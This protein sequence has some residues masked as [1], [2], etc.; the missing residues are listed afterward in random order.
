MVV[1][2]FG[3]MAAGDL[4]VRAE[5]AK[6]GSAGKGFAVVAEEVRKLAERSAQSAK[7]I[8]GIIRFLIQSAYTRTSAGQGG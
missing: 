5:A 2:P 3:R 1:L 6:A 7:E 8:E 4:T